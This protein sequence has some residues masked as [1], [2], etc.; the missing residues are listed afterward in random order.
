MNLIER[1]AEGLYCPPGRFYVDPWRPVERAV[2]TH[3]HAD[4]ARPGSAHYIACD[5]A[6]HVLRVRL[7][8]ATIDTLPFGEAFVRD[9]V[10][11]SLHPAGHVLGAA[12]VRIE[13]RGQ[14]WV[15]SGDYKRESD[16]TCAPLEPLRAHVFVTESTFGL[17]V[18]R[19][20]DPAAVVDDVS[21]WWRANAG[22]GRTSV[23]FCYAF[24]KAQRIAAMLGNAG[25]LDI[26]PLA[27]H[28]A[29]SALNVAYRDSGV[30]LP[31]ILHASTLAEAE[32]PRALV[33]APPSAAGSPWL[34]RFGDFASGFASGWMQTR[35]GRKSRGVEQGF[36][37]SDHADWPGLLATIAETG[38]SRVLVTHGESETLVRW[39]CEQGYDAS[40]LATEFA[41]E[42]EPDAAPAGDAA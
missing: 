10:R 29:M 13:F 8:G 3:A 28:G 26:G 17:P 5:D 37:L 27:A 36:V 9:G 19:W 39:L 7:P 40:A 25:A 23:L 38:A 32:V 41:G 4:H 33:L 20:R 22:A 34:R 16:P 30:V 14:V 12:Q 1:R 24:G 2:I 18:F 21:Q 31:A 11:L 42:G 35:A 6:A 15:V